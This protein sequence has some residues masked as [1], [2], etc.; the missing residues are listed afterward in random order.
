MNYTSPVETVP[1]AQSVLM[2]ALS[3]TLTIVIVTINVLT[4]Y[5]VR[6]V[7]DLREKYGILLVAYCIV[8]ILNGL[9]VTYLQFRIWLLFFGS[10]P[11][12]EWRDTLVSSFDFLTYT[13]SSWHTV[14]LTLDRYIAVC[15]PFRYHRI[16][17]LNV[18]KVMIFAVWV[19]S[20]LENVG[21][22][23][24]FKAFKCEDTQGPI[25][26]EESSIQFAHL[27]VI[28]LLHFAMYSRIWWIAHKMRQRSVE[29]LSG[30]GPVRRGIVDKATLTVFCVVVLSFVIWMPYMMYQLIPS[31]FRFGFF[32]MQLMILLG[33]SGSFINNIIY[34]IINKSFRDGFRRL[35]CKRSSIN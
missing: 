24:Y 28:F 2:W 15:Y 7:D 10:E 20:I 18:Q 32:Y 22:Q 17:S 5:I 9:H 4:I 11:S 25:F 34:V 30:N 26:F 16:M 35:V 23:I 19:I 6:T 3:I 27:S 31:H 29:A 12:C 21:P 13:A 1:T 8:D 33:F 14:L